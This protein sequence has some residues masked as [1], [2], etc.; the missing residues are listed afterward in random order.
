M[1]VRAITV[2]ATLCILRRVYANFN[3][4]IYINVRI[5]ASNQIARNRQHGAVGAEHYQQ[6]RSG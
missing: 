5:S 2:G 1:M 3:K 4:I 6:H